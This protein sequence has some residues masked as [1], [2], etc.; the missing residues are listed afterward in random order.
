[1]AKQPLSREE[2]EQRKEQ[3]MLKRCLGDGIVLPKVVSGVTYSRIHDDHDGTFDGSIELFFGPDGDAWISV[4]RLH[5][6]QIPRA[7][8]FRNYCGG[9]RSL[10]VY[11]ALRLLAEAIRL[12]QE[13]RPDSPD[14]VRTAFEK[15][16]REEEEMQRQIKVYKGQ[17]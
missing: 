15:F 16:F 9:G 12:D 5:D 3:Q 10:R 14:D 8:R 2:K 7:I 17:T 6:H 13:E 4:Q 11:H 1:M